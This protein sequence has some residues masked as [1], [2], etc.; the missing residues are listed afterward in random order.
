MRSNRL[1]LPVLAVC[2]AMA[3]CASSPRPAI[4]QPKPLPAEL[5]VVCPPPA[6]TPADN[7]DDV[8]LALK[9]MYDL[10]GLCAG[11]FIELLNWIEKRK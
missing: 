9:R 3:S 10:Y 6:E 5:A 8:A 11:R 2:M 7:P 4:E 1:L